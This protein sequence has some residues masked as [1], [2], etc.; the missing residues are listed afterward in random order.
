MNRLFLPTGQFTPLAWRLVG[1]LILVLLLPLL[2]YPLGPD[3]GLFF[4]AGQKIVNQGAVPYRDIV[5]VKPPLI[6]YVYG[7]SILL[8]G[9][10]EVS[11]RIL[12]LLFQLATCFFLI[13]LVRR[14][15]GSDRWAATAGLL[16]PVM[17]ISPN[18]VNMS[19][20][21]S[22]VGFLLFPC[23]WLLMFR[24]TARG[25]LTIGLLCGVLTFFK[26]TFGIALAGL[27]LSDL[28]LYDDAWK[29]RLRNYA[30]TAAGFGVVVGAFF[31]FL[32][33]FDAMQ[34]FLNMQEFLSGYTGLQ[35]S[36]KGALLRDA[37]QKIPSNMADEYSLT[38]LF[39]T[40]VGIAGAIAGTVRRPSG[41]HAVAD[42]DSDPDVRDNA[43]RLLRICTILFL[44]FLATVAMEA[45]WLH[46]HFIR[47][48]PFGALIGAFGLLAIARLFASRGGR[49]F[50]W[51]ALPVAA[52]LIL[53]FS[54]LTRYLY[55]M[56][57]AILMLTSGPDA[58]DRYYEYSRLADE[59]TM[60]EIQEIGEFVK[61]RKRVGDKVFVVAGIAG[62]VYL[63]CDH[64]PD[65]H[66]FH[67]CFLIARFAP[68][69]WRD[70]A[71]AYVREQRPRFV[72]VHQTDRMLNITGTVSTSAETIRE[73]MP[74]MERDLNEDYDAVLK[75]TA[76][77]VYERKEE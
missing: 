57:P 63:E 10:H 72:I 69:T 21:E 22:F 36:A 11:I 7:L 32:T 25:F 66:V 61:S 71:V 34:G 24:R 29:T 6:Y 76:F 27:L 41:I 2:T 52:V 58:F 51:V 33:A 62:K 45:K 17:Y 18:Y 16:Y 44:L 12:D 14:A 26:F 48:F 68:Q 49:R 43:T 50:R 73:L 31:L 38:M 42:P 67:S 54:P 55:H 39:A 40:V 5:D 64:V 56:R 47:L 65:F 8:F 9:D 3:N 4:V 15:T 75:T 1:V 74:E 13:V 70:S 23:I 60:S 28:L 30:A 59:W 20:V 46:Y 77:I 35:W 37:L 53:G 19:Q